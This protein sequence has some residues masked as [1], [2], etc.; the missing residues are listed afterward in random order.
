MFFA[1][2]PSL[3]LIMYILVAL[4]F[5]RHGRDFRLY[6]YYI[7]IHVYIYMTN[8]LVNGESLGGKGLT[9]PIC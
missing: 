3:G 6:I 8:S 5:P 2:G 4:E 1:T 9:G 7:Y